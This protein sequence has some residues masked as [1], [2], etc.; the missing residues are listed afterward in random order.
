M[1]IEA[2]VQT[3]GIMK[4]GAA[5]GIAVDRFVVE[6]SSVAYTVIKTSANGEALGVLKTATPVDG[7][8]VTIQTNGVAQIEVL[9]GQ[10]IALSGDVGADADGKAKAW[11]S[12][13]VLGRALEA[14]TA[15]GAGHRISVLL[16]LGQ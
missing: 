3:L 13:P 1:A 15:A 5:S 7:Q 16:T 10:T 8:R 4:S 12:G 2:N 9:A 6:S 14:V 11:V